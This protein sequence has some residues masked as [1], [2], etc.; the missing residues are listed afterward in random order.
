MPIY[1]YECSCCHHEFEEFVKDQ[2]K[3]GK[4]FCEKCGNVAFKVPALFNVNIFKPRK[5]SDGT[6][7]PEFVSTPKQEKAWLKSQGIIYDQPTGKERRHRKE[8]RTRETET[9]L[10]VAFKKAVEKCEQGF[11][12]E[13]PEQKNKPK[14]QVFKV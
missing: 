12:I 3:S 13:K 2:E 1:C 6:S 8:E 10:S 7:T 5:F 11:K 9:S 14:K 4:T